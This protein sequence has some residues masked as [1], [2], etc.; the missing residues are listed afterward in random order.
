M[1][2]PQQ[3]EPMSWGEVAGFALLAVVVALLVSSGRNTSQALV[4]VGTPLPPLMAAGWLNSEQPSDS[5]IPTRESLLG[6]VVVVDCWATWCPPCRA[7]MPELAQLYAKYRPLGVE[8][9]G[10]TS[11]TAN[12]RPAIEEFINSIDGFDWPVGYGAMAIQDLLGIQVLPTV[13][14]FG[15]GGAAVWSNSQLYGIEDALDQA[16]ASAAGGMRN[17]E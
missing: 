17:A 16:L 13:I 8:F 2:S 5:E 1:T 10:L 7:A 6:K 9:I 11:E 3:R 4:P 15:P 14:V 12:D